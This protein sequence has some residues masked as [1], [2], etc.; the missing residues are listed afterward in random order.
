MKLFREALIIFGIY[1]VG[2][3]IVSLTHI[4]IPG[5]IIGLLL[6]LLGLCTKVIKVSQVETVANFFLDHLAFFFLPAGVSLMN[7]FGIIKASIIQII[8]V[9]IITTAVIIAST[10]LIVQFIVNLLNKDKKGT[11]ESES[12]N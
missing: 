8:I 6:L 9:C 3:L 2:E 4:P 5:N 1:L 11:E 10:G 7:S 12:N